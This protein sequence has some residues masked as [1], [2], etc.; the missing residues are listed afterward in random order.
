MEDSLADLIKDVPED[1]LRREA[2]LYLSDEERARVESLGGFEALM[3]ALQD[4]LDEQRERHEGGNKWIGTAGTSPFGAFGYNPEGVRIGQHGSQNRS[5]VNLAASIAVLGKK[6]L[7]V[8]S[9]PQGNASSSLGNTATWT[10]PSS[11]ARV[12]SRL[13]CAGS[14]NSRAK[15]P[16][17]SST[18]RTR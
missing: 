13:H 3:K 2:E 1:W 14:E 9:D 16:P 4:R 10:I 17:T 6:V 5:A 8:D 12:T 11:S 18:S 7:L 15:A